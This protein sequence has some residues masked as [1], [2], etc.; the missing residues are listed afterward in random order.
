MDERQSAPKDISS[1]LGVTSPLWQD[2][3]RSDVWKIW[4]KGT[5][6]AKVNTNSI[7]TIRE[8]YL[9]I[10]VLPSFKKSAVEPIPEKVG[11]DLNIPVRR[12]I[13]GDTHADVEHDVLACV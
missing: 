9:R 10:I 13:T 12:E 8:I 7:G 3:Q 6:K 4:G 1:P 11:H 5:A 2:M